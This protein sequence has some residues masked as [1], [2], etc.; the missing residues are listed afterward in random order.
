[1]ELLHTQG[2]PSFHN[3][4]KETE[5]CHNGVGPLGAMQSQVSGTAQMQAK[6]HVLCYDCKATRHTAIFHR[7]S[8]NGNSWK[9]S[10]QTQSKA[11]QS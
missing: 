11:K 10:E 7:I 3:G 9:T 5:G 4:A 6:A 1:M 8:R 2:Q